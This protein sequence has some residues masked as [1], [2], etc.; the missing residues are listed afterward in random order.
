MVLGDVSLKFHWEL[1]SEMSAVQQMLVGQQ[2]QFST[3]T[4]VTANKKITT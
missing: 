4:G 1:L 2:H 3:H